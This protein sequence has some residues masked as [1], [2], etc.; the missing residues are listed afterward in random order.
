MPSVDNEC[1]S[2]LYYIGIANQISRTTA[3]ME[4]MLSNNILAAASVEPADL[5]DDLRAVEHWSER[6]DVERLD[7]A[8]LADVSEI[9]RQPPRLFEVEQRVR[10]LSPGQP[11]LRPSLEPFGAPGRVVAT[12]LERGIEHGQVRLEGPSTRAPGA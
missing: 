5:I 6:I 11:G 4:T 3:K 2:H 10:G 9:A 12:L 8:F 7:A 1:L